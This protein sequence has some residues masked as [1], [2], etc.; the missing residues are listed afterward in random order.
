MYSYYDGMSAPI[1]R[2]IIHVD[3]DAFFAAVEVRDNPALQG[4]PVAVGGNSDRRGV[5]ATASYE[6]RKF[7][8]R[9]AMATAEA[10]RRCPQLTL[11][12]GRMTVYKEV[13]LQIRGI[14]ARYTELIEPLSLDEAYLDVTDCQ[15]CQGSATRIAERIRADILRETGLTASAGVAPNKFLAKIASDENKPNGQF[16]ITPDQVAGFA[17]NL[18]LRKIPGVGPKSAEKLAA[19]G[20]HVGADVLL[21]SPERL[22]EWF[23]K[24]GPSLYL[25]AQGM[26]DRPV[27]THR[28]RKSVGVETT[29]SA[30]L[31]SEESCWEVL[32]GL[33]PELHRRLAGRSFRGFQVK[34]KFHD[35][36]KTTAAHQ[37]YE[38][39]EDVLLSTL[40]VAYQRAQGRRVRLVGLSASLAK[41]EDYALKQLSLPL[42]NTE[43]LH[44]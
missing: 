16:V 19:L 44:S 28:E 32:L 5:I 12:P 39:S 1:C 14:F 41:N 3:M 9:S 43:Q 35:F 38:L 13:S 33:L 34:L 17:A 4:K 7:G 27:Q 26:D 15:Q 6:A 42:A 30:D 8:V 18:P 2:K 10:L 11:L 40:K 22:E 25:R 36:Q 23:G 24:F 21:H 20:L 37:A 29:L 31:N